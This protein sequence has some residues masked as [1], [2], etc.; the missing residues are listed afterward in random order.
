MLSVT[1]PRY[2]L[3]AGVQESVLPSSATALGETPVGEELT[4][5]RRRLGD[6]PTEE[7]AGS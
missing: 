7:G 3:L 2:G 1:N 6:R 4:T 5:D